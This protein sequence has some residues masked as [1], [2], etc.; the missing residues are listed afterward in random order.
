MSSLRTRHR[1][2]K[3]AFEESQRHEIEERCSFES[4][5]HDSV[6]WSSEGICSSLDDS[7]INTSSDEEV[8]TDVKNDDVD[9]TDAEILIR[10]SKDFNIS[11]TAVHALF[12]ILKSRTSLNLP[13]S[14]HQYCQ[15]SDSVNKLN[16]Q[17][18]DGGKFVYF[19][20]DRVT[21]IPDSDLDYSRPKGAIYKDIRSRYG[22]KTRT[23]SLNVDGLAMFHSSNIV[24]WPILAL[25]NEQRIPKPIPVA[26]FCGKNKPNMSYFLKDLCRE[27]SELHL[28]SN[29]RVV[30]FICDAPARSLV[31]GTKGHTGYHACDYCQ[32]KGVYEN[33]KVILPDINCVSRQD[34]DFG[35]FDDT[36]MRE[37][38]QLSSIIPMVTSFP[39]EYMHLV[40]LGVMRK[41]MMRLCKES[42][43]P[44]IRLTPSTK[45]ALSSK[46][47][48][49]S[50]C[51]PSSE[52]RR[53]LRG[54]NH[55]ER[56]KATEFRAFL[57]YVG[58]HVLKDV[59]N[60]S[61][62]RHFLL[63]HFAIYC[64]CSDEHHISLFK[65]AG[66]CLSKFV[67]EASTHYGRDFM[68]YN[69]HVLSHLPDFVE[70]FGPLDSFSAFIFESFFYK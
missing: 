41:I 51:L 50:S 63:L 69:V 21:S 57:L 5:V 32:Q 14:V 47:E 17:Q 44:G 56:W 6:R 40:C 25:V 67:V 7:S 22:S 70:K 26:L 59:L 60:A 24:V 43:K 9:L 27:I 11:K 23:V 15:T 3:R 34:D 62:Y 38:C 53:K 30:N 48:A 68:S 16:V 19:G 65:N 54:L 52:F 39:P 8:F 18:V 4:S 33:R 29:V 1:R 36:F 2:L 37:R 61:L 49:A 31:K 58:P 46:I 10:W 55:L 64:F 12:K 42:P 35:K 13:S 66:A 20:F 28:H 45:L